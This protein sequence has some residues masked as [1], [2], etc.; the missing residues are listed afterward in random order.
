[1]KTSSPVISRFLHQAQP[2]I[3][4]QSPQ[5][6][7]GPASF[8][9]IALPQGMT[10]TQIVL[11]LRTGIQAA[12]LKFTKYNQEWFHFCACRLKFGWW[13]DSVNYAD[14]LFYSYSLQQY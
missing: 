1:M 14:V 10:Q 3:A 7:A 4:I 8:A 9:T 13:T 11:L 5:P 12:A 2:A 6:T